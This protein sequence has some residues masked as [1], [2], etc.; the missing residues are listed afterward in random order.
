[1][2]AL[3]DR[4]LL[5]A[6][7]VFFIFLQPM[8]AC[9]LCSLQTPTVHVKT[10]FIKSQNHIN[11]IDFEWVFSKNFTDLTILSY[12][13]NND[14]VLD[15]KELQAVYD[16]L[17]DYI[18]P[19]GYLTSIKHYKAPEG[20]TYRIKYKVKNE[21]VY[22]Q[23]ESLKFS[24]GVEFDLDIYDDLVMIVD[25]KDYEGYFNFGLLPLESDK[26]SENLYVR[27]NINLNTAFYEFIRNKL[28]NQV[29][30]ENKLYE[31][32]ESQLGFFDYLSI[33]I[34]NILKDSFNHESNVFS[35]LFLIAISLVYGILHATLPGHGKVLVASYFLNQNKSYLKAFIF[36]S[37]VGFIHIFMSFAL[38]ITSLFIIEKIM[39]NQA[40]YY[41]VKVNG[42]IILLLVLFMVFKKIKKQKSVC[43]HCVKKSKTFL[44]YKPPKNTKIT[45]NKKS[46]FDKTSDFVVAFVAGGVPC[47]GTILVF[48]L[49]YN[50]GKFYLAFLS[51]FFISFGMSFVIFIS[52]V[53]A[54]NVGFR[55]NRFRI[56][57]EFVGLFCMFL[58]S[59]WMIFFAQFRVL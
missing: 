29:I 57:I 33:K 10:H 48:M 41:V 47:P 25:I 1:M 3:D 30:K 13:L 2:I 51:A 19:R 36:A 28:Q 54:S 45:F 39:I 50:L 8:F 42:I 21:K 31:K 9:A 15:E 27:T 24:F 40:S 53:L 52:A 58:I 18:K 4:G 12:D 22:I 6:L 49:A 26:I 14:K 35:F 46:I 55:L 37:K 11:G 38:T 23:D 34:F 7:V 17:V 59:L 32:E 16:S 43:L 5:R 44:I 56:F 20:D